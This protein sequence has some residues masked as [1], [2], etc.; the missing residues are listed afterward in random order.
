MM[1][2]LGLDLA[3][4]PAQWL[5]TEEAITAAASDGI[6]WQWGEE[7]FVFYGGWN[8]E[9]KRSSIEVHSIIALNGRLPRDSLR[10]ELP[11]TN[12]LL[13]RR[14][15]HTCAYCG[16]QFPPSSLSDLTRPT[17]AISV[18]EANLA[19]KIGKLIISKRDFCRF[20]CVFPT[21]HGLWTQFGC[22]TAM[23]FR[24]HARQT[25]VHSVCTFERPRIRN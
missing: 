23:R 16:M 14:D 7:S 3:G 24:F 11:L 15:H 2:I 5:T 17:K 18:S 21:F 20:W 10:D 12:T 1:Q 19:K 4:N 25:S 13:F 9:G 22:N 8:R 6:A